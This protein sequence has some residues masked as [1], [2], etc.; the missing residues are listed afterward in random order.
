MQVLYICQ[1][2]AR[3]LQESLE[4][5][6]K[7]ID[8]LKPYATK[9]DSVEADIED[10][11]SSIDYHMDKLE[12]LENQS[13]RNNIRV[14]GILEAENESWDATEEK[15]KEVLKDKLSLEFESSIERAHR[16]GKIVTGTRRRPRTI[17]CRLRDWKQKELIIKSRLE[18]N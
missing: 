11:Y 18:E 5:S 13:R 9:R 3:D 6:Q 10:I 2:D 1:V 12:Y 7:D 8:E 4:F 16:V 17:V 14:D 15:V